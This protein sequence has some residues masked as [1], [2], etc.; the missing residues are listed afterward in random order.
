MRLKADRHA[1]CSA[2]KHQKDRIVIGSLFQRDKHTGKLSVKLLLKQTVREL[3][4]MREAA[5]EGGGE[6]GN[7]ERRASELVS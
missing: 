3:S 6:T 2:H 7:Y 1:G 5:C 4:H